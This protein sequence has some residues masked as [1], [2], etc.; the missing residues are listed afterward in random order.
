M[1]VKYRGKKKQVWTVRSLGHDTGKEE[2][3]GR[4]IRWKEPRIAMEL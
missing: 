3:E 1:P 2:A 4:R